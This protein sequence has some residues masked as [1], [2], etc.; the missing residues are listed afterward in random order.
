LSC[1]S[2][3]ELHSCHSFT[4]EVGVKILYGVVFQAQ[5]KR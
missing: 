3:S 4:R 2:E 1:F 5:R